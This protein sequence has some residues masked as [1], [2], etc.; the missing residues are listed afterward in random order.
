M[1][2]VNK[3]YPN[4]HR[5][6]ETHFRL[7]R[8]DLLAP[9]KYAVKE[10]RSKQ[11]QWTTKPQLHDVQVYSNASMVGMR[12][13]NVGTKYLIKFDNIEGH[14]MNVHWINSKLL[15]FNS[16]L[17]ISP[18][19]FSTLFWVVVSTRRVKELHDE[20][21]IG[22]RSVDGLEVKFERGIEYIMFES[23]SAFFEAY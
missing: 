8:E 7:L 3:E 1:N 10:F 13:G 18:D 22:V 21:I 23:T 19:G 17:C 16:L 12:A 2:N 14:A 15:M 20:G 11:T 4:V 9:Y 5:Y 6:L